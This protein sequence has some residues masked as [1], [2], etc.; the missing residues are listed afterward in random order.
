[1]KEMRRVLALLLCFVMLVG[2]VPVGALAAEAE[3]TAP[4]VAE[5]PLVTE[6]TDAVEDTT[7]APEIETT[8]S[9]ETTEAVVETTAAVET[10]EA[11]EETTEAVEETAPAVMLTASSAAAAAVSGVL[12]AAI[13]CSDV[14]GSSSDLTSVMGGIKTSGVTYSA[15]GFVGDTCLTVAETKSAVNSG[16]GDTPTVMFS[17]ASSHDTADISTNWNY[18]GEVKNVSKYYLVYTV[19]ETDMETDTGADEDFTT[20]YNGLTAEEKTLPIFIM[21][22]RP[23]HERRNDN[24]GAAGWYTAVS[25]A[26]ETSDIVFFWAHNHTG[27][28]SAD[29]NAYYVP[30]DGSEKITVAGG[31]TVGLNFTY[32]NAG[33]INANNQN[34]ARIGVA[35]TVQITAD[36]LVFQ[37]YNESGE[38][39]GTYAHNVEVAREFAASEPTLSSIS[40]SGETEYTVGDKLALTVTATYSDG[41]SANI[42]EQVEWNNLPDMTTAGT[43]EVTATYDGVTSEAVT[44]TVKA[45]PVVNS[46]AVTTLPTK[47]N[48]DIGDGLDTT[49]MVVTATYSDGSTA[50]VTG[51]YTSS[52]DMTTAGEKTVTVNYYVNGTTWQATYKITVNEALA[53]D[54]TLVSME[55]TTDPTTTEYQVNDALDIS[56]MV[57]TAT[58]SDNTTKELTYGGFIDSDGTSTVASDTF[59]YYI[60]GFNMHVEKQQKVVVSYTYG[61]KTLTDTFVIN[62]WNYEFKDETTGVI[63]DVAD[64]DYGVTGMTVADS[65]N[66]YV[67]TAIADYI[68]GTNYKAYDI[69]LT[70]DT[71]VNSEDS[72]IL[73][74]DAK[75]V[76]LP[77][78]EGVNNPVVCYVSD[79]G[80]TVTNMNAVKDGKGNVTFT[81]THFSTYVIGESTEIEV[82]ENET[83]SGSATTEGEKTVYVLTSSITSGTSYLVVNGNEAGSYY[84]LANNSG[85]VTATGVTVKTDDTI[86]TYI[87]LDDATDELWTVSGSRSTSLKNSS[88]YL[89]YSGSRGNYSLDLSTS[90]RSWT[91]S[92]NRLSI[93]PNRTTY[94]LVY[95]S[96]WDMSSS[97]DNIYFYVPTEIDTTTTV[98]G[99]YTITGKDISAVVASDGSTTANLTAYLAFDNDDENIDNT[100]EDVSTTATYEIVTV[101]A[102]GNTVDGDPKDIITKIENGVVYFSGTYGTALV[103][104]SYKTDFG[105]VTDYITVTATAPY[106]SVELHKAELTEVSITEFAEGVTYYTYNSTTGN[107][108]E[109]TEY[110]EGTTYYTTPVKQGD[111]ITSTIA[112]KGVEAGDTYAVW[113]V[114]TEHTSTGDT[115]LGDLEDDLLYWTVSDESIATI[116]PATGVITFTGNNYGTFTV[117]VHYLD[118]DGESLCSDTITIS[119]TES[120]YVVPGDGTDDFPEYPN[121]GAVRFDKTATAVGNFSETG[122]AQVELSMT[123]V[124]YS[125][126]NSL[127][128]LLML[129]MSTSM[130]TE[131]ADGVDRVDVTIT[132]AKAFAKTILVNDD[133]SFTGNYI[134]IKY[135][136]GSSVYTTTDYMTVSSESEL[137]ALYDLIEAL[138]T[139]NSSGT[140]YSVAMENAYDTIIA[141]DAA[142]T[143][144]QALVFMSDGGPTYYTYVN[145][146]SYATVSNSP[147][148]IVGWFD[149]TDTDSDGTVDTATAN[150]SFK[151]EYYSYLLKA[152]GYPV[153]TVGLGLSNNDTGPSA[154]TG[155]SST[156]H[157]QITSYI[158]AQMATSSSYFYSIADSDAV[159]S[160]GN[161]FSAIAASIKEAATDV[162]VEDKIGSDYTV[163]FSLPTG[164]TSDATDG[165][166]EFYI[167]VVD[168]VLDTTTHERT[169]V[170]TVL[171]N[172]TFNEDGSL[173]SHTVDGAACGTTCSH[174]TTTDGVITA[175]NGTYFEY[176]STDEGEYLTWESEKLSSTELALQYFVYL[177]NSAGTDV[178]D[179]VEPGT[180]YTNEYATLTYTNVNSKVVQQEFPI[181]QMTWYGAQVSYVFYLVNEAG[182]PVNR[183][184][185]VVPFAEAVYVT[186]VY[187]YS[188]VWNDLEQAAGLEAKYLAE[189]LVPDVYALYDDDAAYNIHVYADEEGV[190]LNNH[191]IIGGDVTDDYNTVTNS[192]TNAKTTYVF[193]TKADANKYN[194]HGTYVADDSDATANETGLSYFCKSAII[195]GATYTTSVE[196]DVTVHTVTS[197]GS[198]YQQVEGETQATVEMIVAAGGSTTGGTEIGG[199]VYYVDEN[200]DVYTI[201]QKSN[202]TEV[203]KGFDFSNTTVAFAVVWKPQLEADTVV[204]DY[205][206]D[207]VIDV[208]TNDGMAAG[209]V[210]VLDSPVS[211][212]TINSGTFDT[213]TEAQSVDVYI[214]AN[215]DDD[216]G[217]KE[218]KIG[219]ATVENLNAVR[220]SLNKENG[221]QFTDPAVFYYEAGVNY[222]KDNVL[223]TTNMYSSVTVIPATTVYYEEDFVTLEVTGTAAWET[224]GSVSSTTQDQDRPGAS[225]ITAALDADNVYGYDSAYSELSTYS[226]G[227]A[228]KVTV[229]SGNAGRASFTFYGTGFD[230]ISMTSSTTGT[231]LVKV[232]AVDDAG[233]MTEQKSLIVDT[234]YGMNADGTI[235]RDNPTDELYQVPVMKVKDLEY[236]KYYVTITASYSES[237]DHTS[238]EGSYDFY[239]DAI[240]IF[241]PTGVASG[242]TTNDPDG[243]ISDAYAAD[244]ESW[245]I[246]QEL[247]EMLISA[248]KYTVTENEDG[249]VTVTGKNLSGAIFIDCNNATTSIEDYVNHGPNNEVYLASK[250]AVS[251]SLD[252]SGYAKDVVA[253]VQIGMKSADG[254]DV[255]VSLNGGS[256]ATIKTATDMYYS[257]GNYVEL[258]ADSE[259]GQD[260]KTTLTF[261]NTGD[262][263][264]VSITNLKITFNE[265]PNGVSVGS[266]MHTDSESAG[267]ALM[268]LRSVAVEETPETETTEPEET[269]P[270]VTEPEVTEPEE[271]LDAQL[272]VSVMNNSVKV[273]STVVVKIT[274]SSDVDALTVNGK[275]ISR[276]TENRFTGVR[277]WTT[278]VKA[279][280]AGSMDIAVTAYNNGAALDTVTETIEVSGKTAGVVQQIVGQLIGMLF[281]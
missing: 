176:V 82:P 206:L 35:T 28:S 195:E 166:S 252:M 203:H 196:N 275:E 1:M 121:Q 87:E 254:S 59:C 126:G 20:W 240:R 69:T 18:S 218:L 15:I 106:Y 31:S 157:E 118:E 231:I 194:A 5:E 89:T 114:V 111:Q 222:Y 13:F 92:S 96:G 192:W 146:S 208:I 43:F 55:I 219:T 186:D 129:D 47:T 227:A 250:Q 60:D 193:N 8:A 88:H 259:N 153:Y 51:W 93:V 217:L 64:G 177:D 150:S 241:D 235:N 49:G 209:V 67:S 246:Y 103:K 263:G 264:I 12:D 73:T 212:T 90:S 182:Q 53:D 130:D 280:E 30:N 215:N 276:Y 249:T 273:G 91:Y 79:D 271:A 76:T 105:T 19:R 10:T 272:K 178:D 258:Y 101:D 268:S 22:H 213:A 122:L 133:G 161:V 262:S 98:E 86:G 94:Y 34:P 21:S 116:D 148:T 134:A 207:V 270:E 44:I 267:I 232:Y 239:L 214:D 234:Y 253:D 66:N 85:S 14:H 95:D 54:V 16:L 155:L 26:A 158:L 58:F 6:A 189:N 142:S 32:M 260:G 147:S 188:V 3:T 48:Y 191:F 281:G 180:Y 201:V 112:L 45:V 269:E 179:Q 25:A 40:I 211:N 80:A 216:G 68:T 247:R 128:V 266:L 257:I 200:G 33:Y 255:Y 71:K 139:P 256:P 123:G 78:P 190:N 243:V 145:G 97:S 159:S 181:P 125:T 65:T 104:V 173:K 238:A 185:K 237:F 144:T 175:I 140:Y 72:Y 41:T 102:N 225:K 174:V 210:G 244:G 251:F 226:N 221:M 151:T 171:E 160:I 277:T 23:L 245:P 136:N 132:A 17:Y 220:F 70:L 42:T 119:A 108:Q 115:D 36:S 74:S 205:G 229:S 167:Q 135:F 154:F 168:Y 149:Q 124:P 202:G 172:F 230:V 143:N 81:T 4:S 223:Q 57:V 228:K 99:T 9:A 84:A 184:G 127:D 117:T 37:D 39:S 83:A 29:T 63:V 163:N 248:S 261:Q 11:V 2:Y 52:V 204:V 279:S 50:E 46:I 109:A 100:H 138:Y 113:A 27:E 164:V 198:G 265:N 62:V 152:A 141:R 107:Y 156:I 197:V 110:V 274:T 183:A 24:A 165:L 75:T 137:E 61:D 77:I 199:Y 224:V 169:G 236:G 162:V 38:Y 56:G 170:Y 7:A 120:L 187:T 131:V 233:T 278:T 242:V